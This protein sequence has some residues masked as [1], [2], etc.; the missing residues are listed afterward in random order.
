MARTK[1]RGKVARKSRVQNRRNNAM[2]PR[3]QTRR[4]NAVK[5]SVRR[6]RP[7]RSRGKMKG[8]NDPE[9]E[10]VSVTPDACPRIH[11]KFTTG[12]KLE[13]LVRFLNNDNKE[14][15]DDI[16]LFLKNIKQEQ[17]LH[18]QTEIVKL[19]N[20]L[21]ILDDT[22]DNAAKK[23]EHKS[24]PIDNANVHEWAKENF[25]IH[26]YHD[27]ETARIFDRKID[28]FSSDTKEYEIIFPGNI[29]FENKPRGLQ[30]EIVN[31]MFG[32]K[33]REIYCT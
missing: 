24:N 14:Y 18:H 7:R 26:K 16:R 20:V 28:A 8:G 3:V 29:D 22:N 12:P 5:K 11:D 4:N 6:K 27:K 17:F 31:K 23:V 1:R 19:Q 9:I 30:F 2:K 10:V 32:P 15:K 25:Y 33:V 13:A 21:N